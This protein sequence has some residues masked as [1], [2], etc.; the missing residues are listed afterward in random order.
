[1]LL[2][3]A[4]IFDYNGKKIWAKRACGMLYIIN[5][6]YFILGEAERDLAITG[7]ERLAYILELFYSPLN[8]RDCSREDGLLAISRMPNGKRAI[9]GGRLDNCTFDVSGAPAAMREY[10]AW[11]ENIGRDNIYI[12]EDR[13][14]ISDIEW[15]ILEK[16]P[17]RKASTAWLYNEGD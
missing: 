16:S 17:E 6:C 8:R 14:E 10:K 2:D 1:M 7:P 5:G 4:V 13:H 9:S 3:K 15:A 11:A 12:A